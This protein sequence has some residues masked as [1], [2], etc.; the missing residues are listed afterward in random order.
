MLYVCLATNMTPN[1]AE[2]IKDASRT[3]PNAMMSAVGINAVLG[4]TMLLTVCFTIGDVK[5]VIDT[6]TGYPF[7]Q[8]FFDTTENYTA[9]NAMVSILIVSLIASTITEIA[10]ASR[11]V[12]S[13]A[14]DQGLPF[15][16]LLSSVRETTPFRIG[17]VYNFP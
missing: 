15:S 14:R 10:T 6:P 13:F 17:D 9:T 2:E 3:L 5:S 4:F 16:G 8:I 7:I 11:Q 12:W 1:I